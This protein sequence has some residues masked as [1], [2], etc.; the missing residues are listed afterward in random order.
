MIVK[1]NVLRETELI[2]KII[3]ESYESSLLYVS[4]GTKFIA[5]I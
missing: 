2:A 3:F 5:L 4:R 1:I